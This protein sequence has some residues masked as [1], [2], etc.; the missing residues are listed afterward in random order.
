VI[1]LLRELLAELRALKAKV[2]GL[3]ALAAAD[4]AAY[5]RDTAALAAS[6]ARFRRPGQVGRQRTVSA[7]ITDVVAYLEAEGWREDRGRL[8]CYALWLLEVRANYEKVT[9]S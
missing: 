8:Q 9:A 1:R 3:E 4:D 2:A 5:R 7:Q 6:R